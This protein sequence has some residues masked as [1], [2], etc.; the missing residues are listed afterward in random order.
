MLTNTVYCLGRCRETLA[1][2]KDENPTWDVSKLFEKTGID[3]RFKADSDQT[4]LSL[5]KDASEKLLHNIDADIDGLIYVSQSP[6]SNIP[7]TAFLLHEYLK[8]PKK[9][10]VYDINQGCAGF[11]YGLSLAA[12]TMAFHGANNCL[13]VCSEVYNKY[14]AND[15]R[16]CRPIFSDA[17]CA[18]L[19]TKKD[20][21]GLGVFEFYSDGSGAGDLTLHYVKNKMQL[22]MDGPKVLLFAMREVPFAIS[23]LLKRE[24]LDISEIDLFIFHQASKLVLDNIQRTL[25][26]SSDKLFRHD[27]SIGN[28][29]SAT[30]GIALAQAKALGKI[31]PGMKILLMGFGVGLSLAGCIY[32]VPK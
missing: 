15:D 10:F 8:L 19:V 6:D 5:A 29:V 11:I 24:N 17:A 1:D 21:S 14:I 31:E 3:V 16:T 20:V 30:I 2:L 9:I 27:P 22:Y 28:T 23:S 18:T 13:L 25:K 26:I 32:H 4:A 7:G 12:A